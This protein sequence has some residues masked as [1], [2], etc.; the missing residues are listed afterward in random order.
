[1]SQEA[2]LIAGIF[3]LLILCMGE[4]DLLDSLIKLVQAT[5]EF[6]GRQSCN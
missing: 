2:V 5:A 6:I 4:P 1:M 3:L